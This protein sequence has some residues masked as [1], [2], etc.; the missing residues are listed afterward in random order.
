MQKNWYININ[1][2]VYGPYSLEN[3]HLYL[4]ENRIQI[5]SLIRHEN[6]EDFRPLSEFSEFTSQPLPETLPEDNL[7]ITA[8]FFVMA[9][10]HHTL[11]E[12]FL[13]K[14]QSLGQN[15]HLGTGLW[16]IKTHLNATNLRNALV[17]TL[18]PVNRLFVMAVRRQSAWYNIS[19]DMSERMRRLWHNDT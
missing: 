9:E 4:V 6:H 5:D 10:A 18:E 7:P 16:L 19:P 3:M 2:Q 14:L 15:E 13:Q 11:P 12:A 1:D 8:V 17:N